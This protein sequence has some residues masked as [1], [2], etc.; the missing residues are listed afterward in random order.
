ML[1]EFSRLPPILYVVLTS[2]GLSL[3]NYSIQK[4]HFFRALLAFTFFI[5]CAG[6]LCIGILIFAEF[7]ILQILQ[8][9][10]EHVPASAAEAPLTLAKFL[11]AYGFEGI[12]YIPAMVIV[13]LLDGF[14]LFMPA[15]LIHGL[16]LLGIE[17]GR[18][19]TPFTI[20]LTK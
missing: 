3:P 12:L 2:I 7:G 4:Q 14:Y 8:Q 9:F 10:R 16:I 18:A 11:F 17:R 15:A 20:A 13:V 6:A 5:P 19:R 1:D